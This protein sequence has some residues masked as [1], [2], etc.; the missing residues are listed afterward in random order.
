MVIYGNICITQSVKVFQR[1]KD[2]DVT[3]TRSGELE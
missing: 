1:D 3:R 2:G